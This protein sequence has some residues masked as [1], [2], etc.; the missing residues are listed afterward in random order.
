MGKTLNL[1]VIFNAESL[2]YGEGM[3]NFSTLKKMVRADGK[4]YSY[5]SRQAL[6]YDIARICGWN[7][8]PVEDKGVAQ[9]SDKATIDAYPEID[10]F[11]YMKTSANT[12]ESDAEDEV[13]NKDDAKKKDKSKVM[14]ADKRSAVARISNAISLIPFASDSDYQT[15]MGLAIR[16][17]SKN[18][19][20]Q[21]EVHSSFYSYTISVE[22]DRVGKEDDGSIEIDNTEKAD[23]VCKLLDAVSRLERCI[24]GRNEDLSPIFMIG[25]IY[26]SG[27]P[28][29]LNAMK[30]NN[31][32]LDCNLI[33]EVMEKRDELTE[34]SK[35][36]GISGEF[37]N[38]EEVKNLCNTS[39]KDAFESLKEEVRE[40]YES[41]KA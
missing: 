21:K 36:A 39:I 4:T 41:N 31:G 8:T 30:M 3:G 33:H 11:G 10:L 35:I 40:Y 1:T 37:K 2:N 14:G 29:F 16:N 18:A 22:L 15:N 34:K 12:S 20:A 24:R 23:R 32:N 27:C 38:K 5:M 9:F 7:D 13:E 17:N 28:F 26:Q 25:G 19:I 6:R